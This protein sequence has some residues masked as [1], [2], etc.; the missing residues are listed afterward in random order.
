MGWHVQWSQIG[1]AHAGTPATES[2]GTPPAAAAAP[3]FQEVQA[4]LKTVRSGG[5]SSKSFVPPH[6]TPAGTRGWWAPEVI[7]RQPY[8]FEVDWWC[9]GIL[10]SECLVGKDPFS[11]TPNGEKPPPQ[12]GEPKSSCV[13]GALCARCRDAEARDP[14]IKAALAAPRQGTQRSRNLS[15]FAHAAPKRQG[16]GCPD[17]RSSL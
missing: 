6:G 16:S 5:V 15:P 2:T 3:P 8:R 9:L 14:E 12:L 17:L 11:R 13:D 10:T 1:S 4:R 7:R